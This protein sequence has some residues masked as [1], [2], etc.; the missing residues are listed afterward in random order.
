MDISPK[1]RILLLAVSVAILGLALFWWGR[2]EEQDPNRPL[3]ELLE[4]RG[5]QVE[6]QQLYLV[7]SF[8]EQSIAQVLTGVELEEAVAASLEGGGDPAAVRP[9]KR[10]RDHPVFAGWGSGAVLHPASGRRRPQGH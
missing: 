10:G 4:A 3:V 5:Y 1:H 8:P 7:G 6:S 9:G 2:V